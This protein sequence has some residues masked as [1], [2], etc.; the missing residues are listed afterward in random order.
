LF[1]HVNKNVIFGFVKV[2]LFGLVPAGAPGLDINIGEVIN[3]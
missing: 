3:P 2:I 1:N